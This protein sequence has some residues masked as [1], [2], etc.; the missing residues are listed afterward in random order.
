MIKMDFKLETVKITP[1]ECVQEND[2]I[3]STT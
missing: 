1:H 3:E 2:L